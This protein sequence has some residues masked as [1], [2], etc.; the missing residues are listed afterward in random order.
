MTSLSPHHL[1]LMPS[2]CGAGS[3]QRNLGQGVGGGWVEGTQTC[4]PEQASK[5]SFGQA[6][7]ARQA[8]VQRVI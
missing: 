8:K 2:R 7:A 3:Q 5:E 6:Q 4:N 1:T